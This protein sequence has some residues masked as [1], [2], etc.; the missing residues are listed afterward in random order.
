MHGKLRGKCVYQAELDFHFPTLT[1][2][3]TL[4]FG[5]SARNCGHSRKDIQQNAESTATL[6]GLSKALD[7]KLGNDLI[8]GV[9]GG[10]RKRASIAVCL[11]PLSKVHLA[12]TSQEILV[13]DSNFQC[14]DNSTR[15]LDS[16]NALDFVKTLRRE[17]TQRRSVAIVTLY[18]ASEDIY[19]VRALHESTALAS[20]TVTSFLT[21]YLSFMK[22]TRSILVLLKKLDRTLLTLASLPVTGPL[23]LTFSPRLPKQK[24][25]SYVWIS[26]A[27]YR[28]PPRSM[29]VPGHYLQLGRGCGNKSMNTM[30]A[31]P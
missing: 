27:R 25:A 28:T 19:Q 7:T 6:L 1:M 24:T 13:G 29:Q 31:I 5:A 16:S 4:E 23:H 21:K 20:L 30:Q 9:S 3:E 15:G 26:Q 18:Q 11:L 10:E 22:V 12:N 2:R 8:P 14:W 17:T